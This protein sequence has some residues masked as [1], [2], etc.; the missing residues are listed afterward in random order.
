MAKE[1]Y[2]GKRLN[3]CDGLRSAGHDPQLVRASGAL[4]MTFG[5]MV[6]YVCCARCGKRDIRLLPERFRPLSPSKPCTGSSGA[7]LS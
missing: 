6:D 5:G 1:E 2:R 4:G 3:Y 7:E